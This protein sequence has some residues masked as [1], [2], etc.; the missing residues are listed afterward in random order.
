MKAYNGDDPTTK[1][2]EVV[3]H[4]HRIS[5]TLIEKID[6]LEAT[7]MTFMTKKALV[8]KTLSN[9]K[10]H[11]NKLQVEWKTEKSQNETRAKEIHDKIYVPEVH[12]YGLLKGCS[13]VNVNAGP[14]GPY[15]QWWW[16]G[17][18]E[19]K[20]TDIGAA[21]NAYLTKNGVDYPEE[22]GC[23]LTYENGKTT[24]LFE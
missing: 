2:S 15:G 4:L 13:H 5:F 18:S 21:V 24:K 20:A 14:L 3:T 7:N 19:D 9:M 1:G 22:L 23:P 11:G 10:K 16:L 17:Y 8:D 6:K 12:I